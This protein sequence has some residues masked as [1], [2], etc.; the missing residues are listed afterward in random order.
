MQYKKGLYRVLPFISMKRQK[1]KPAGDEAPSVLSDVVD[2]R[3]S[4]ENSDTA[5][6]NRDGID[7]LKALQIAGGVICGIILIWFI[8]H[9]FLNIV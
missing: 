2:D 5:A 8:L 6:G 3:V 9:T 4:R 7:A 1:Q